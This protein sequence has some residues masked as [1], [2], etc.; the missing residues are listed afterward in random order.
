MYL[1]EG[2]PLTGK[3]R[4]DTEQFLKSQGLEWEEGL[5]TTFN[6]VENGVICATGSRQGNVL[7]CIAVSP[8]YQG[9]GIPAAILTELIKDASQNG[10]YHLFLYTK[11]QNRQMFAGYGFYEVSSTADVLLMENRQNGIRDFLQSLPRRSEASDI[12]GIVANCN[13]FTNGHLYLIE[14]AAAD[15]DFLYL[16]IL[17]EDKSEFSAA[18]RVGMVRQGTAHLSNLAVYPTGSYLISSATFPQY[19][20]K[21]KQCANLIQCELDLNI[22]SFWFAR[23]FGITKRY[24]GSEPYCHVTS[25]YNRRMSAVL[26][27]IG[28]EVIELARREINGTAVSA[29]RVRELLHQGR[30]ADIR[31]LVPDTTYQYIRSFYPFG[32]HRSN[33]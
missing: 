32:L 22:F 10:I 5:E 20:L 9:Q 18:D 8:E 3:K 15:C 26:P 27:Q 19:F 14:Q 21:E 30:L 25:E 17:S 16:F 31:P 13:P 7:K 12:G 2:R 33:K 24:V 11:P 28:I 1:I 6:L 29:S 23:Y 4:S